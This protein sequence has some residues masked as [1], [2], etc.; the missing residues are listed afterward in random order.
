MPKP[1]TSSE[2]YQLTASEEELLRTYLSRF[3]NIDDE[4]NNNVA[5]FADNLLAFGACITNIFRQ[6]GFVATLEDMRPFVE[7][8]ELFWQSFKNILSKVNPNF[9][10]AVGYKISER[11]SYANVQDTTNY[12]YLGY[13]AMENAL[14][15]NKIEVIEE[16]ID[17]NEVTRNVKAIDRSRLDR[18]ALRESKQTFLLHLKTQINNLLQSLRNAD[19][20]YSPNASA[21]DQAI[22]L[23]NKAIAPIDE[24]MSETSNEA[25]QI[26][27]NEIKGLICLIST[28]MPK[29]ITQDNNEIISE[30]FMQIK[31]IEKLYEK[32]GSPIVNHTLNILSS[33]HSVKNNLHDKFE[34][35][36]D[37]DENEQYLQYQL[38]DLIERFD[39]ALYDR[40]MTNTEEGL[41]YLIQDFRTQAQEILFEYKVKVDNANNT[42]N[43]ES[44]FESISNFINGF[45]D[46]IASIFNSEED[47]SLVEY[48]EDLMGGC[49]TSIES[50]LK[51]K[52]QH[53]ESINDSE[54]D[55]SFVEYGTDL[56][57]SCI[58]SEESSLRD[59]VQNAESINAFEESTTHEL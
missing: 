37:L 9:L 47:V 42:S 4:Q 40:M 33:S 2:K 21:I 50:S 45:F 12:L 49:I 14:L 30:I 55:V 41:K 58:A 54:V 32:L 13:T 28:L 43:G 17:E 19:S 48:S 11:G 38:N 44:W 36:G 46:L 29:S 10:T 15:K 56:M 23:I 52:A 57:N 39:G 25:C 5:V 53:A 7:E 6:K 20:L 31:S 8:N 3:D 16:S 51:N 18:M 24:S 27:L 1:E 59:K 22:T 35:L 26:K 34:N